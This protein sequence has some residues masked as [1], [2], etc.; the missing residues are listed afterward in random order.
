[1]TTRLAPPPR[2]LSWTLRL[3]KHASAGHAAKW[4]ITDQDARS[5]CALR[6]HTTQH[7]QAG[8]LPRGRVC[9]QCL[10]RYETRGAL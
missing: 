6:T 7:R 8:T 5:L 10:T 3:G 4:H 1:M 9:G 2:P